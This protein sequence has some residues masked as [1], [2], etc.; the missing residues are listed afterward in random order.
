[1]SDELEETARWFDRLGGDRDAYLSAESV[2][3][4]PTGPGLTQAMDLGREEEAVILGPGL[5]RQLQREL[6]ALGPGPGP[7]SVLRVSGIRV[8]MD[9][10]MPEDTMLAVGGDGRAAR[11]IQLALQ[12]PAV[13][14]VPM[15]RTTDEFTVTGPPEILEWTPSM[16]PTPRHG[17]TRRLTL[18]PRVR[19]L[20]DRPEARGYRDELDRHLQAEAAAHHRMM[21]ESFFPPAGLTGLD[22]GPW[23]EPS[24]DT[25]TTS[26]MTTSSGFSLTDLAESLDR[27]ERETFRGLGI[28]SAFL[29][30][31][32]TP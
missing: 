13:P 26:A 24:G 21:V 20:L 18:D 3:R 22:L 31:R 25:Y 17:P 4:R 32:R 29:G 7:V 8:L 27:V 28:P 30:P 9:R 16:D 1:M 6:A 11:R 14:Q 2:V 10:N 12:G 5:Y 19:A 23:D 15:E